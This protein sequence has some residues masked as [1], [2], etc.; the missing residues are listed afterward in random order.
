MNCLAQA[1]AAHAGIQ[2]GQWLRA[3]PF[4]WYLFRDFTYKHS[5]DYYEI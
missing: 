3:F 2:A 1:L 5:G 4:N